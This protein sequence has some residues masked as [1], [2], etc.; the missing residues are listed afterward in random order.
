MKRTDGN[1]QGIQSLFA[2]FGQDVFDPFS[3]P[4]KDNTGK[5]K[6]KEGQRASKGDLLSIMYYVDN[7]AGNIPK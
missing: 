1:Q 6:I 5:L 7:I 4:I 3:G 2:Q